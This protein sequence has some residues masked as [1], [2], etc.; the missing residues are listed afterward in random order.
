MFYYINTFLIKNH[1]IRDIQKVFTIKMSV[2][3]LQYHCPFLFTSIAVD[4]GNTSE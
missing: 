1:F 3:T 2:K 4:P